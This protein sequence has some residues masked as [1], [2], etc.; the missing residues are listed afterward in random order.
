MH[1]GALLADLLLTHGVEHIFGV[2]GGQTA[3]LYDAILDRTPRLRHV[4]V[5]DERSGAW[6]ADAYARLTGRVGVCDATVGPGAALLP[7]G[8]AEAYN[9]S[10][11][12]LAIVSDLPSGTIGRGMRYRGAA[13]QGMDQFGLLRPLT[14]WQAEVPSQAVLPDLVRRAFREATTGRPGP[15]ALF[16]PHDIFDQPWDADAAPSPVASDKCFG[17][18]P[19]LR[20]PPSA[21]ALADAA[22]VLSRAERP[23]ILA[24]GG[25]VI[26]G[27]FEP[28]RLLAER[29]GA[30]VAT[31]LSGKGAISEQH[32]LS[33]GVVGRIGTTSAAAA[34][35]EADVVLLLGCKSGQNPTLGWTLPRPDQAVVQIDVDPAELG[36]VF[37]QTVPVLG[38][39]RLALEGL[40][41]ALGPASA[42]HEPSRVAWGARLDQV[43]AAWREE[44]DRERLADTRPLLPQRVVGE[45]SQLLGPE[46][47]LVC[48]ASFASGWGGLY[49]EQPVAGRHVLTPRGTAGLGFGLPAAIGAA[50]ARPG[51]TVVNLAGDGALSYAIGELATVVQQGLKVVT[52]VLNNS[53]LGYIRWYRRITFQRGHESEDFRDVDFAAVAR[54]YGLPAWRVEDPA[55]LANTLAEALKGDGPALLDVRVD[56]WQSPMFGQRQAVAAQLAQAADGTADAGY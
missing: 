44:R 5:R 12:V 25:A 51:A 36:K 40:L 26:A 48:D 49:H 42:P 21:A 16:I 38:D 55:D 18:Y 2:P 10:I 31:S 11:P 41:S 15:V 30:A 37:P 54:G 50:V 14:K 22:A 8:L 39:A 32:P 56:P 52:V 46:D 7:P 13:Q 20:Q 4:L 53:S 27:A 6:A 23:F 28:L 34:F 1:T 43:T 35:A 3:A 33:V 19:A 24:G 9:S 45:L 29:L 17:S 47:V